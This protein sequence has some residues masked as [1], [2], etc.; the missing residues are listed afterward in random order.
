MAG[1]KRYSSHSL[2]PS[3]VSTAV[4]HCWVSEEEGVEPLFPDASYG[5][6]MLAR[7][8]LDRDQHMRTSI[9]GLSARVASPWGSRE[10]EDLRFLGTFNGT[11]EDQHNLRPFVMVCA[12]PTSDRLNSAAHCPLDLCS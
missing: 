9:A 10:R 6:N 7:Q 12:P 5:V 8:V 3:R 1:F 11:R 4:A 2:P